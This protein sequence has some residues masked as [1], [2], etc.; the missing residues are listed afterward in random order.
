ML[1]NPSQIELYRL[2]VLRSGL[3]LELKGIKKSGRSCYA[4][5]KSMGYKGSRS[6][7]LANLILDIEKANNV[8]PSTTQSSV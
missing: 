1:S 8:N 7:V 5:L 4:I 6:T 3:S 2:C